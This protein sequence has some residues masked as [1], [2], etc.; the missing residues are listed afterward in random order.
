MQNKLLINVSPIR[1][2]LT[3]IGYYTLNILIELLSC[4]IELLGIK[5]GK[6]VTREALLEL[7]SRFPSKD[8]DSSKVTNNKRLFIEF[9]R[10]I[11][12]I[13]QIK[14]YLLSKRVSKLLASLANEGYVYFEPS[15]IPFDYSGI[16]IT[17][18]HDLS[19]LSH[20]EFHPATRVSYL[21]NKIQL[22]IA[23]SDHIVVDSEFILKEL[24]SY[25]PSAKG[26]SSTLYLG[27][28]DSFKPYSKGE[29]K[30]L[31]A[32]LN[33]K[34]AGYVLSVATLE[35]R[36]NLSK[37]IDAYKLL[38]ESVRSIYPLVLVGDQGWKNSELL[39]NARELLESKQI[40]FTGYVADDDLKRLYSSAAV[41][42]Y[43]SLY[44]GFGL[45]VIEA[46]ASGVPVITSNIGATAEVAASGAILVD[47]LSE[48]AIA[49]AVLGFVSYPKAK[50]KLVE[51]AINRAK[52]FNWSK[53]VEQLLKIA[54]DTSKGG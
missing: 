36:K 4:N 24:H 40:L 39:E 35:P 44:E 29:C 22:A 43:P 16:T 18:I 27:V 34:S 3:G 11:P 21:T 48:Q 47:P 50:V 20:P 5:N 53:T 14:N 54:L 6:L 2:P 33:I 42:V 31:L 38:P 46:M 13:Y 8:A 51:S 26:K 32:S 19:F 37:L 25:F 30:S 45:P 23:S 12:G 9:V 15:F 17:T 1:L 7:A 10:A 49:Q 41:F 52:L 28:S